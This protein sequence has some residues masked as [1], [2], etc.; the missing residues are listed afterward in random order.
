MRESVQVRHRRT[1]A[2]LHVY[3]IRTCADYIHV[4]TLRTSGPGHMYRVCI[5]RT[6]TARARFSRACAVASGMAIV[7]GSIFSLTYA[8]AK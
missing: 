2:H 8:I 7:H 1:N 3:I 5:V 4:Y 6:G